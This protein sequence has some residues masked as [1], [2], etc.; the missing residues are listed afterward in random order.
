[1]K[2]SNVLLRR[3]WFETADKFSCPGIGVTAY[4]REDAE[5]LIQAEETL[6]HYELVSVVDDV[7]IRSLDQNHIVPNIGPVNFRGIWYPNLFQ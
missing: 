4:S 1:M 6:K 5:Q 7:D 3:F 2:P